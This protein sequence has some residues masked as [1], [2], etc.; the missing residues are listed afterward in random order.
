MYLKSAACRI[1]ADHLG[2]PLMD[3]TYAELL[4]VDR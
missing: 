3:M 1:V 2:L 4:W